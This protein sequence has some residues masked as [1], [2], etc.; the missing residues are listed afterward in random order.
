LFS[1]ITVGLSAS[2]LL[3][4]PAKKEGYYNK[5]LSAEQEEDGL[6]EKNE[7]E[8]AL[9]GQR[10]QLGKKGGWIEIE[11]PVRRKEK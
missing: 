2:T 1:F 10:L 4:C 9:I 3:P 8:N 7:R 5:N 11:A 6:K